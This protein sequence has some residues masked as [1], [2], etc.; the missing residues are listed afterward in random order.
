MDATGAV[1][2]VGRFL[3]GCVAL[4]NFATWMPKDEYSDLRQAYAAASGVTLRTAQRHQRSNHP[5]WQRFIG[6]T[7]G[8]AVK[9]GVVE[10]AEAVAL[11]AVSPHRPE[12]A[13]GFYQEDERELAP[14][15]INEKRAWEIHDRTFRAWREQLDSIKG[16]PVV[17]LVYAKELPKLREDYEKARA[18]RER[19]EI[20]QRRLIPSHEFERFVGQFLIPLAELLKNLPVEL[21]VMMNPD[22]PAYARERVL[23]WLRGKAEPQISEM[24]RG[25]DEFLAA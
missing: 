21:P 17:A 5:D 10:K 13:P 7:A 12:E 8:Q 18:A 25:A 3:A 9:R 11:A 23:E 15:Q 1:G 14:P 2:W 16:E 24:L 19:W 6:V 4:T 22:N 20:E